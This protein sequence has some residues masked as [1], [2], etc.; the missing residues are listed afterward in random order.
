MVA[1]LATLSLEILSAWRIY[2]EQNAAYFLGGKGSGISRKQIVGGRNLMKLISPCPSVFLDCENPV[3]KF[4]MVTVAPDT[5]ASRASWP[6]P[7]SEE[8]ATCD[9][10]NPQAARETRAERPQTCS[11]F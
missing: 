4:S 9:T 10:I 7:F 5:T 3:E 8:V 2:Q 11:D 1:A 6:V